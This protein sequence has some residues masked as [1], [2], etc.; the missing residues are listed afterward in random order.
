M[1][2]GVTWWF[3]SV[4]MC[5]QTSDAY[6]VRLFSPTENCLSLELTIAKLGQTVFSNR[7]LSEL[8]LGYC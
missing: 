2:D 5:G 8:R 1:G 3:A 7:K 4:Q 6:L